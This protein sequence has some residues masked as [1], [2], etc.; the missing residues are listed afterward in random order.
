MSADEQRIAIATASGWTRIE[1]VRV[2]F[3]SENYS[4]PEHVPVGNPPH[5]KSE[6]KNWRW[7][8]PD[9]INN[10]NAIHESESSLDEK[11]LNEY[12]FAL[13]AVVERDLGD[14]PS[15]GHLAHAT[16]QQRAEAFLKALNLW[17]E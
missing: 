17:T 4:G 14:I 1:M 11:Q 8:V 9:Y 10:L 15:Y 2:T 13:D 3:R 6:V 12:G 7:D 5:A 16:A